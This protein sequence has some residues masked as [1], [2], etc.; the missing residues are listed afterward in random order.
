MPPLKILGQAT[1]THK[2]INRSSEA[3][4]PS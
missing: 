4:L 1:H 2:N 3:R